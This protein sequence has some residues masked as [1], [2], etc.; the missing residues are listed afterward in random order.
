MNAKSVRFVLTLTAGLVL[1]ANLSF[2][3]SWFGRSSTKSI[4]V[5]LA[6]VTKLSDGTVLEPGNYTI[7]I[8]EHTQSP[9]VQ[10]YRDRQ[11]VARVQAKVET[12]PHKNEYTEI[13]MQ[14]KTNV[15]TAIQPGGWA[16]KLVFSKGGAQ[17]S[18]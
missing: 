4:D 15:I 12:Q 10:F 1:T 18:M 2:A 8:P 7:K 14:G 16:E 3:G 5:D 6:S 17:A 11:L 13:L 9:Q